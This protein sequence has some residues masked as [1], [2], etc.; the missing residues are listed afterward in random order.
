MRLNERCVASLFCKR[1]AREASRAALEQLS[2]ITAGVR[3]NSRTRSLA[4]TNDR[5]F[6]L[7]TGVVQFSFHSAS[8]R[9][10][11][12]RAQTVGGCNEGLGLERAR[13]AEAKQKR[14]VLVLV[15]FQRG[16]HDAC[17]AGDLVSLVWLQRPIKCAGMRAFISH[18]Q[19]ERAIG[20]TKKFTNSLAEVIV[21]YLP[22]ERIFE[23]Q[24]RLKKSPEVVS[25]I[26]ECTKVF[27]LVCGRHARVH[28]SEKEIDLCRVVH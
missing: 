7:E 1:E 6:V 5:T 27:S 8:V 21:S 25:E 22:G 16:Q 23:V 4:I 13:L 17:R 24:K 19:D 3:P 14:V 12:T 2:I 9:I 26:P 20:V 28:L 18:P 11:R 10:Q 15:F